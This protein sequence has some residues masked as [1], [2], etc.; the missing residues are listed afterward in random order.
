MKNIKPKLKDNS[1]DFHLCVLDFMLCY[2]KSLQSC[3]TL[4]DPI[5][6]SPPGSV[7][8]G[9]LQAR[10]PEWVA[11]SFSSAW[12]EKSESEVSQSCPTLSDSM[13]CSLPGSSIHGIFQA[14]VLEWGAI[15][16]T[17]QYII[18]SWE[19]ERLRCYC[20][21]S[22][23]ILHRCTLKTK[24]SNQIDQGF[25]TSDKKNHS[26]VGNKLLS[27]EYLVW[28]E[29]Y[30]HHLVDI[31]LHNLQNAL[32][33]TFNLILRAK[34]SG[35]FCFRRR[36]KWLRSSPSSIMNKNSTLIWIYRI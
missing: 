33:W 6:G 31:I 18:I 17:L 19:Q 30:L 8:P 16:L 4:C 25:G 20:F 21:I 10:I 9:I 12:K 24:G 28:N 27:I 34:P 13:D 29:G 5:D 7:I 1:K 36:S 2:A 15:V 22:M 26:F 32:K 35:L 14:R 23:C 3:P 11:I